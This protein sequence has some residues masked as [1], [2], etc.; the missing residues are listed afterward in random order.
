MQMGTETGLGGRIDP[1]SQDALALE[2]CLAAPA[3]SIL[4]IFERGLT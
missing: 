1:P 4:L 3:F 2:L